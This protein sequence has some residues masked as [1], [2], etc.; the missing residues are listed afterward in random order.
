M[1]THVSDTKTKR[2]MDNFNTKVL[3][4][5]REKFYG[6]PLDENDVA[7][8]K[9]LVEQWLSTKLLEAEKR[10]QK[11]EV[12]L[13]VQHNTEWYELG[14]KHGEEIERERI[15]TL[16]ESK[17]KELEHNQRQCGQDVVCG[18]C[19]Q[20]FALTSLAEELTAKPPR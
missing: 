13:R 1:N 5:F 15:L 12:A 16:I 6:F 18:L 11:E 8:D 2:K 7:I 14:A 9:T 10:V 3:E 17:K 20:L 19:S 4:E